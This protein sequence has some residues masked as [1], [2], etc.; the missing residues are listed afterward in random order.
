MKKKN[1][2]Y[3]CLKEGEEEE[4]EKKTYA[5]CENLNSI[6]RIRESLLREVFFLLF[7]GA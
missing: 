7:G 3:Y 6:L 2:Y 1:V 4:R 5:H